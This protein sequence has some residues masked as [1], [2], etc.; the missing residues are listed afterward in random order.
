MSMTVSHLSVSMAHDTFKKRK[1]GELYKMIKACFK[2]VN[3]KHTNVL[4]L[5]SLLI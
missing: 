3:L 4:A 5:A 1:S 2:Y